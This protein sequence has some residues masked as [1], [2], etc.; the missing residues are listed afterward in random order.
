MKFTAQDNTLYLPDKTPRGWY[1][2]FQPGYRIPNVFNLH[3]KGMFKT[4][5][6][7]EIDHGARIVVREGLQVAVQ[8][9]Q[10]ADEHTV[11]PVTGESFS[12]MNKHGLVLLD[13]RLDLDTAAL[14][15]EVTHKAVGRGN[16]K[17][18]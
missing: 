5:P 4:R 3:E 2:L 7:V 12:C 18:P 13:Q 17:D 6:A 14:D 9:M 1:V 11:D 10:L 15:S 8:Y 16:Q